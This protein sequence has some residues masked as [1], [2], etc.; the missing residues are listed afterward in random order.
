MNQVILKNDEATS[1]FTPDHRVDFTNDERKAHLQVD[2]DVPYGTLEIR[3]TWGQDGRLEDKTIE[4]LMLNRIT[5][6]QGCN[7]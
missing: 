3:F 5:L 6:D 4:Y 2:H 1:Q 7:Q